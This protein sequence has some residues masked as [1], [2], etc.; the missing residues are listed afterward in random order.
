MADKNSSKYESAGTGKALKSPG[1]KAHELR[2]FVDTVYRLCSHLKGI[3]VKSNQTTIRHL[4]ESKLH[5]A[6][7]TC[8]LQQ[9]MRFKEWHTQTLIRILEEKAQ[10]DETA[11]L[12]RSC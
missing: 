1:K 12:R 3:G 8:A 6:I 10:L 4:L 5:C 7:C 11:R 2:L 9:K